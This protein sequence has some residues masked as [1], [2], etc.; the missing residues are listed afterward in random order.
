MMKSNNHTHV[1]ILKADVEG[2]G[3]QHY[4]SCGPAV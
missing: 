1:Y 4:D 3:M 2:M